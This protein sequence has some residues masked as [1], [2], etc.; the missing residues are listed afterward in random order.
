MDAAISM[1]LWPEASTVSQIFS[2]AFHQCLKLINI[3]LTTGMIFTR[4]SAL[5]GNIDAQHAIIIRGHGLWW[6]KVNPNYAS[7]PQDYS[8]D[9]TRFSD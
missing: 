6:K 3:V 1:L 9:D 2:K 8:G 5:L 7:N 4:V